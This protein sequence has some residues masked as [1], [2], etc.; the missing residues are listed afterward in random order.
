[1][2]PIGLVITV[3]EAAYCYGK[4]PLTLEVTEVGA[5]SRRDAKAVDW[6]WLTGHVIEWNGYRDPHPKQFLVLVS[7]LPKPPG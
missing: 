7:A 4:G 3:P 5:T 1:M 6:I 2:V